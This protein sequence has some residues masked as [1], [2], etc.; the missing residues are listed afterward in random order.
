MI[1]KK[2]C[3]FTISLAKGGAEHQLVK[4]AV[5]FKNEGYDVLIV[6]ALPQNDFKDVLFENEIPVYLY[7]FGT[8]RG[9]KLLFGFIKESKP[10]S[11]ISFMFGANVIARLIKRRFGT[12]L[13]TSVRSS[14]ISRFYLALY[15][16]SY[17]LDNYTVF[18]SQFTLD[19]FLSNRLTA[20]KKSLYIPNAVS[21]GEKSVFQ[22]KNEKFTLLSIAHFRPVKDY[23]TLFQAI[24]ILKDKDVSIKVIV[25]GKTFGLKWPQLMIKELGIDKI[26][27]LKGYVQNPAP[28]LEKAN[29]L[30]L[31]T[32]WEG[33]PN[34]ILE[35]M[36]HNLPIITS[37]VPGCESLVTNAGSGFLFEKQNPEELAEKIIE[38]I[39]LS[40]QERMILGNS[41]YQF[42]YKNYREEVVYKKWLAL[43]E[44]VLELRP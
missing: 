11:L 42:V 9:L 32:F 6:K 38:M 43:I 1:P 3:F 13:I 12:P 15:K 34:A 31:S 22:S 10:D 2:I 37:R 21:I 27:E 7:R 17:K 23:K 25:V 30:V 8:I 18:N 28:F 44:K 39:A 36:A 29:A 19:K 35:G 24:K 40:E 4:L 41:G 20:P 26:L 5:F 33:T 14:V 16:I